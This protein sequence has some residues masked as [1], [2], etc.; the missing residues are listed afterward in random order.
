MNVN[1]DVY[2]FRDFKKGKSWTYAFNNIHQ[3]VY[4]GYKRQGKA[5]GW[6][7]EVPSILCEDEMSIEQRIRN[8][9]ES[10]HKL[11]FFLFAIYELIF[12]TFWRGNNVTI[13]EINWKSE[14]QNVLYFSHTLIRIPPT[15]SAYCVN[16]PQD[17]VWCPL[18]FRCFIFVTKPT[19]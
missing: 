4:F 7:S 16:K 5:R 19:F 3:T 6:V 1:N 2:R 18:M 8:W 15:M 11:V 17:I 10:I 13:Y 12:K 9:I 14:E